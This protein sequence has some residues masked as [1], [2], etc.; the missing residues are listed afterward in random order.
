VREMVRVSAKSPFN[1]GG[2]KGGTQRLTKVVLR[3]LDQQSDLPQWQ[4][5]F[6]FIYFSIEQSVTEPPQK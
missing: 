6:H 1:S 5:E 4:R 3:L 2:D